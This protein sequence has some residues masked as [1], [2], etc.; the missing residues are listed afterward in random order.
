MKPEQTI[1]AG[2][3]IDEVLIAFRQSVNQPGTIFSTEHWLFPKL[4][5]LQLLLTNPI[6]EDEALALLDVLYQRH[7]MSELIAW[8]ENGAV[9]WADFF[10]HQANLKKE[11]LQKRADERDRGRTART[12]PWSDLELFPDEAFPKISDRCP[13]CGSDWKP[14]GY[15]LPSEDT[16]EDAR[17]GHL[18]LGGCVIEDAKRYC[19]DC[20]NRWPTKPDMSRPRGKPEWIQRQ[21]AETLFHYTRLCSLAEQAPHS[22]EPQVEYAWA[23]KTVMSNS[24][25]LSAAEREPGSRKRW[26]TLA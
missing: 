8:L 26:N 11:D 23:R 10:G 1:A 14:I 9:S 6:T 2:N 7:W 12:N 24:C 4:D 16:L 19:V 3:S 21:I 25:S 17:R 20:F 18:V 13:D 22:E 15:G 5:Q